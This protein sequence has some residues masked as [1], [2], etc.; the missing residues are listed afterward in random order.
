MKKFI[1]AIVCLMTMVLSAN[2]HNTHYSK[3][4]IDGITYVEN[5]HNIASASEGKLKGWDV[6]K[7]DKPY[8]KTITIPYRME[9][10]GEKIQICSIKENAFSTCISLDSLIL[11]DGL[12]ISDKAFIGCK[13][14]EYLYYSNMVYRTAQAAKSDYYQGLQCKILET[15]WGSFDETFWKQISNSLEKL[16][17][18]DTEKIHTRMDYCKK[19]KTIVCYA[20]N[21]PISHAT[22]ENMHLE[23]TVNFDADQWENIILYVPRESL[24]KYYFDNVWGEI[25][26]IYAIDEMPT[27]TESNDNSELTASINSIANNAITDNVWYSLNGVKVNNPTK[28]IYIKNGKKYIIN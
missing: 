20:I 18:R 23:C 26:N 15:T 19:L 21:P 25:D 1:M 14:L 24:E 4:T 27:K 11:S 6:V 3:H 9:V 5:G 10:N 8:E 2:A 13:K 28:G 16:I 17:I 12:V 7:V 22:N